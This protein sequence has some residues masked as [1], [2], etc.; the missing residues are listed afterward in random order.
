MRRIAAEILIA[1]TLAPALSAG[2]TGI[3][4]IVDFGAAPNKSSDSGPAIQAAFNALDPVQGGTVLCPPG[5]YNVATPIVVGT[6]AVRFVGTAGLSYN[7]DLP[8]SGCTLVARTDNMTLLQF[9]APGGKLIHSGPVI[10]YVN[11]RE[12]TPTGHTAVLIDIRNFNRWTARNVAV[13]F[14]KTGIKVTGIDDASWGYVPQLFC[15][16]SVTCVDQSTI[17]GGFLVTGG[18]LEPLSV[19]VR[20]RGSQAR[21][22]GVKFDCKNA[23][24][25]V[26]ITG[27]D[28]LVLGSNFEQ[29]GMGVAVRDDGTQK[30][31]GDQ[32]RII[33][34]H[35]IGSDVEG[36]KGISL[37]PGADDNQVM[38]NTYE[39]PSIRVEDLG[40]D[41]VR[42]EEG[43][44]GDQDVACPAGQAVRGMRIRHGVV[45]AVTCAAP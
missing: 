33:G 5:V 26:Y 29:C 6:P 1:L 12:A 14:A 25:G 41:N 15:K 10:E 23:A 36:S 38:G 35:F 13:N 21:V 30:W 45:M 24:T 19:G 43:M 7:E 18:G 4:N 22:I 3:V 42:L 2:A 16:E 39:Y 8:Y 31:N 27:H 11:F 17:E 9:S 32:N 28:A 37:G 20:V 34:N 44:A 40:T